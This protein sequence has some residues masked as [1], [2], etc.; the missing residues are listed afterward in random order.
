ME[1]L[2]IKL[3]YACATSKL[4]YTF[5]MQALMNVYVM[6]DKELGRDLNAKISN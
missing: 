1:V 2:Q 4:D 5:Q 3:K 6:I